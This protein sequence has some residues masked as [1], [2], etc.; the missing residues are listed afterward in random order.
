MIRVRLNNKHFCSYPEKHLRQENRAGK[1]SWA[2]IYNRERTLPQRSQQSWNPSST[3]QWAQARSEKPMLRSVRGHQ[4]SRA[5]GG[6]G[7]PARQLLKGDGLSPQAGWKCAW[8]CCHGSLVIIVQAG[9]RQQRCSCP[10]A[11]THRGWCM[12]GGLIAR[13]N[14]GKRKLY[15]RH[16]FTGTGPNGRL[17]KLIP[18]LLQ[19]LVIL[20]MSVQPQ[21]QK[22]YEATW[23]FSSHPAP[24][25]PHTRTIQPGLSVLAKFDIH[26]IHLHLL[27]NTRKA[28]VKCCL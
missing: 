12:G 10:L 20:C 13:T 27:H 8:P 1:Q 2:K 5:L 22:G 11:Y 9:I 3:V 24:A 15:N 16:L 18:P 17:I 6:R 28:G 14:E 4:H 23:S 21:L 7:R 26:T 19:Q 25:M